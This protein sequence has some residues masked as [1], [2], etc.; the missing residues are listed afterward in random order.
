MSGESIFVTGELGGS[1]TGKHLEFMPR[2]REGIWLR[3]NGYPSSMIDTSDGPATDLRHVLEASRA[4]A[5]LM[6][7]RIPF[8]NQLSHLAEQER[9]MRAL[10]DGEDFEL[11]FTVPAKRAAALEDAWSSRFTTRLTCIGTITDTPGEIMLVGRDGRETSLSARGF[12][13]FG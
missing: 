9:V 5:K 7:H 2:V 13:H 8:S 12:E 6:A 11:L 10:C 4:G 1:L 3:E